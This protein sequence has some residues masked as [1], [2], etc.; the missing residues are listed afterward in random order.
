VADAR[1]PPAKTALGEPFTNE[2]DSGADFS[3]VVDL[4]QTESK[5]G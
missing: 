4:V 5:H 3:G 2:G 1:S